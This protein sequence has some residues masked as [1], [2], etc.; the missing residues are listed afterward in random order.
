MELL[1]HEGFSRMTLDYDGSVSGTGRNAEG[2]AVGLNR[3]RK[4]ARSCHPL[5]CTIAR[6]D[7]VPS[8]HNRPGNVRN[9]NGADIFISRRMSQVRSCRPHAKIETRID[10]AFLNE[11]IV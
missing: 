7:Q 3:K 6:T 11:T 8:I 10:S 5:F 1:A 2:T 4:G 9:S